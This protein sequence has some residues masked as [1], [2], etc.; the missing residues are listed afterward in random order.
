MNVKKCAVSL[1]KPGRRCGGAP[2]SDGG[3]TLI[4]LLVVIAIIAIL[5]AMLLPALS[6]AKQKAQGIQCLNNH[7]QLALCW[8]LY[9][10]DNGDTLLYAS[11]LGPS[12]GR[13]PNS[14]PMDTANAQDPNNFA[15]S[16]AHMDFQTDNRANYDPT[17]DMEQRPLWHYNKSQTIYKCP[18][19]NSVVKNY[20]G[21]IVPRIMTMS[22]N[23]YVG[24][25][26]PESGG[27]PGSD[28][29][30]NSA[31]GYRIFSKT[32]QIPNPSGIYVFLDMRE[33]VVNWSNFMVMMSGFNPVSPGAWQWGDMPGGYHNRG[34]GFSFADGHSEMK[35]WFDPRTTP[36]LAPPMTQLS[37]TG[38]NFVAAG[39]NNQDVYW[40]QLH[41]TVAQ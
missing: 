26:A 24:G 7:R 29:G 38:F 34:S 5:A 31:N 10:E 33:D 4:E 41:A 25:F 27:G 20:N 37:A 14:V 40:T 39:A 15:W 16:G 8:R 3:F 35:H 18:S 30:W 23:L 12:G 13:S 22:I 9:N 1:P 28:G 19:D 36:P 32:T 17:F 2:R 11:T 21:Q 6:K